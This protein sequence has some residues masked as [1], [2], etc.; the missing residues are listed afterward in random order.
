MQ[1]FVQAFSLSSILYAKHV[2]KYLAVIYLQNNTKNNKIFKTHNI[3]TVE[4]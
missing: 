3:L 4:K 1:H 2:I